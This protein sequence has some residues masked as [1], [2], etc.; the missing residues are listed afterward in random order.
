MNICVLGDK[1]VKVRPYWKCRK[2]YA[3]KLGI[4]LHCSTI[5]QWRTISPIQD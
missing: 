3:S 2:F 5:L 4:Y 1:A